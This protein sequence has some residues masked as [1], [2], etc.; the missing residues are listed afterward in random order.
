M[1]GPA[2]LRRVL[3]PHGLSALG[4]ATWSIPDCVRT[5]LR[6]VL[7]VATATA[8]PRHAIPRKSQ[9]RPAISLIEGGEKEEVVVTRRYR[10]GRDGT[11]RDPSAPAAS[12]SVFAR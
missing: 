3:K 11:S 8:L 9:A 2:L 10:D 1:A 5:D 7:T 12:L 4:C 6:T